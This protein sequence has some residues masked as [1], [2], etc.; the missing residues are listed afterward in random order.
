MVVVALAEAGLEI[1]GSWVADL[2]ATVISVEVASVEV[3]SV[4]VASVEVASVE[5]DLVEVVL[6]EVV[7]AGKLQPLPVRIF[8]LTWKLR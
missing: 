7:L 1:V 4:G 5:V 2:I 6:A 3:A 8:G